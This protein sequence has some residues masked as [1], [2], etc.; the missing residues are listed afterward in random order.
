[1]QVSAPINA[2]QASSGDKVPHT[3]ALS[4]AKGLRDRAFASAEREVLGRLDRANDV[5]KQ[6]EDMLTVCI[7]EAK[8]AEI[9]TSFDGT[10]C[11]PDPEEERA[12][13]ERCVYKV[14]EAK[15]LRDKR[16][17]GKQAKVETFEKASAELEKARKGLERCVFDPLLLFQSV[18]GMWFCVAL[19]GMFPPLPWHAPASRP[20][21]LTCCP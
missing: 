16:M 9:D 19:R 11:C 6:A 14:A 13:E 21:T 8:A 12:I 10:V 20:K 7:D 4:Y 17:T 1:M 2:L 3:D 15:R 18:T 5:R